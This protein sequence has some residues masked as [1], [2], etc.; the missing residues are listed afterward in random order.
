MAL[1]KQEL[2]AGISR[3]ITQALPSA[4]GTHFWVGL[5]LEHGPGVAPVAVAPAPAV[6]L[7]PRLI[8]PTTPHTSNAPAARLP[9]DRRAKGSGFFKDWSL[10]GGALTGCSCRGCEDGGRG[11]PGARVPGGRCVPVDGLGCCPGLCCTCLC[12]CGCAVSTACSCCCCCCCCCC[13]PAL[14]GCPCDCTEFGGLCACGAACCCW[15]ASCGDGA[16]CW[17]CWGGAAKDCCPWP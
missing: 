9:E 15:A 13:W 8:R 16:A 7:R 10:L 14:G 17:G 5:T 12:C 2:S 1:N 4:S 6:L 11:G 3:R